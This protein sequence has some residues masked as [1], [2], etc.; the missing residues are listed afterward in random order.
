LSSRFLVRYA[1][2]FV[3]PWAGLLPG[4]RDVRLV[5]AGGESAQ[6]RVGRLEPISAGAQVQSAGSWNKFEAAA[7]LYTGQAVRTDETGAV[8]MDMA[9]SVLV[10]GP[11]S[12][13]KLLPSRVLTGVLDHGRVE[14]RAAAVDIIRLRTAEAAV[15]GRGDMVMRRDGDVT[16]ITALT[17]AFRVETSQ[18]G[19]R[20]ST[21]QGVILAGTQPP[22]IV[23]LPPPPTDLYPSRDPAYVV[24]GQ[25][26]VLRWKSTTTR[27]HIQVLTEPGGAQ[28]IDK[29]I[30]GASFSFVPPLGLYRW[31]V[32]SVSGTGVES[33]PSSEGLICAVEK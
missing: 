20:V 2:A 21:G 25:P 27:E 10:L 1:A 7:P 6:V 12:N 13:F 19:A 11:S 33:A 23:D 22:T 15:E 24:Q 3:I 28:I 17:G 32:S 9:W 8:F 18:G 16:T 30:E 5:P 4:R 29:E 14:Q 26:V 31:R